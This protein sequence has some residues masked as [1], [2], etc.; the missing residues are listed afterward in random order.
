MITI[1]QI[2]DIVI[3][4]AKSFLLEGYKCYY[5]EFLL[6][7]NKSM[8]KIYPSLKIPKDTLYFMT[9]SIS[10]ESTDK[11]VYEIHYTPDKG[12]IKILFKIKYTENSMMFI[13]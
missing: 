5:D 10:V 11:N 6:E 8:E 12:S 7:F 2:N 3:E 13:K 9:K 4:K 1:D